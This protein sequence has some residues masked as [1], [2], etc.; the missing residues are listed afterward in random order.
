MDTSNTLYIPPYS[1][2]NTDDKGY[3][4]VQY[5]ASSEGKTI[6]ISEPVD[7]SQMFNSFDIKTPISHIDR[8]ITPNIF[9]E[10]CGR[11]RSYKLSHAE[12][13]SAYSLTALATAVYIENSKLVKAIIMA[14]PNKNIWQNANPAVC[15][16]SPKTDRELFVNQRMQGGLTAAIFSCYFF[17]ENKLTVRPRLEG[18]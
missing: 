10:I 7:S 2:K 11:Y 3:P 8:S 13:Y 16:S 15:Q 12:Y 4:M 17:D 18:Q 1:F 9:F 5:L 14:V 6:E